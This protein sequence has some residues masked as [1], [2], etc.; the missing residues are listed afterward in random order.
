VLCASLQIGSSSDWLRACA[1]APRHYL[2]IGD[3]GDLIAVSRRRADEGGETRNIN[4]ARKRVSSLRPYADS[5]SDLEEEDESPSLRVGSQFVIKFEYVLHFIFIS[6]SFSLSISLCFSVFRVL[7][8]CVEFAL[9]LSVRAVSVFL[10]LHPLHR[11]SMTMTLHPHN[12]HLA[13]LGGTSNIITVNTNHP[14][15]NATA[16]AASG[17]AFTTLTPVSVW[18]W[19]LRFSASS[20]L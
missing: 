15:F 19:A 1:I 5:A 7:F 4:T 3:A 9:C 14:S 8:L 11:K 17:R 13:L 10:T 20:V 16:G 2:G 12:P 18:A 6:S